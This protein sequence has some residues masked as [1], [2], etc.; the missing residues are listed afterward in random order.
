MAGGG[1]GGSWP[2]AGCVWELQPKGWANGRVQV[3]KWQAAEPKNVVLATPGGRGET[4]GELFRD[5]R[6]K[7]WSRYCRF[8]EVVSIIEDDEELP[9]DPEDEDEMAVRPQGPDE[10]EMDE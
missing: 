7:E 10:D 6:Q 8:I 3:A 1:A 2:P 9:G 4:A 5:E